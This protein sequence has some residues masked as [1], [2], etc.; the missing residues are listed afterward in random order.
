[1]PSNHKG[2]KK[3][4]TKRPRQAKKE[5]QTK[6]LV[7][8]NPKKNLFGKGRPEYSLTKN[9]RDALVKNFRPI[10][11]LNS[12]SKNL[13]PEVLS[14][15][16]DII[17]DKANKYITQE[18][19]H[20]IPLLNKNNNNYAKFSKTLF[21]KQIC[22]LKKKYKPETIDYFRRILTNIIDGFERKRVNLTISEFNVISLQFVLL[23]TEIIL[24][25][26][27]PSK[28]RI[29][30]FE[31]DLKAEFELLSRGKEKKTNYQNYDD[32]YS[33]ILYAH[34][35]KYVILHRFKILIIILVL[36]D[37]IKLLDT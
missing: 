10:F 8:G 37:I 15:A 26:I 1:M 4:H 22:S 17:I 11:D 19:L 21:T 7:G 27:N 34:E 32:M 5:R 28:G 36:V 6:K 2:K 24:Q 33:N 29:G 16:I 12:E 35:K 23:F 14:S 25:L 3:I 20:C 31:E 30:G 13:S 9:E 18:S